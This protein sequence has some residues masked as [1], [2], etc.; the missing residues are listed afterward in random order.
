MGN[1]ISLWNDSSQD[2]ILTPKLSGFA[3]FAE[4]IFY[5]NHD[6]FHKIIKVVI[7]E[8]SV[9]TSKPLLDFLSLKQH[10]SK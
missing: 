8:R 9:L 10:Q 2:S 4:M 6:L 7:C 3:T 5:T 1:G